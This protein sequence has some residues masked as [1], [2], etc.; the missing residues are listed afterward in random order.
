MPYATAGLPRIIAKRWESSPPRRP[1]GITRGRI[2]CVYYICGTFRILWIKTRI[3][4]DYDVYD[5]LIQANVR[6]TIACPT[7]MAV[8]LSSFLACKRDVISTFLAAILARIHGNC[9][10]YHYPGAL[11]GTNCR[12]ASQLLSPNPLIAFLTLAERQDRL[13]SVCMHTHASD[14]SAKM[15]V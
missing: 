9:S 10:F 6:I 12:L 4:V 14:S 13:Y 5:V 8:Y 2:G 7:I 15:A 1:V 3:I 11:H